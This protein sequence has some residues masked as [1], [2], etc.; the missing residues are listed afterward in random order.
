MDQSAETRGERRVD[1][2]SRLPATPG[3]HAFPVHGPELRHGT[4]ACASCDRV[5]IGV[6]YKKVSPVRIF[7]GLFFVYAPILLL[8]F[9]LLGGLLVY[10]HLR[11][12]GAENLRTLGSFLPARETHRYSYKTQI[13]YRDINPL[14]RWARAR[15]FWLFNCTMYCPFSVASLEWTTYLTKVVENWWC[16]FR[17]ERKPHYAGS[18]IDYSFW[19]MSRD[20]AQLAPEDRDN[21][22]WNKDAAGR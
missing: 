2:E 10:A 1:L 18:A 12:I 9:I 19:H 13:V 16:P 17:H 21:P 7:F 11:L 3:G 14:A 5:A 6:N 22:I 8:P 15:S 4:K 20:V